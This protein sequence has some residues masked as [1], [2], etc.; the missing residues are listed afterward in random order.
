MMNL[1]FSSY[2]LRIT[3][4]RVPQPRGIQD[5]YCLSGTNCQSI[6]VPSFISR[7]SVKYRVNYKEVSIVYIHDVQLEM[8]TKKKK[9]KMRWRHL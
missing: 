7:L 4:M 2:L 9:K 5:N 6:G 3:H 8:K 1:G